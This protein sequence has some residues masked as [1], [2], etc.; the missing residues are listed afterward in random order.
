MRNLTKLCFASFAIF[1]LS[2]SMFAQSFLGSINGTVTDSTGAVV[3]ESNVTLTEVTTGIQQTE[4]SNAAGNYSFPDLKPGTYMVAVSKVGFK[5]A[6][7][8]NIILTAN[9]TSRFDAVLEVGSATQTIEVRALAPTMNTENAEISGVLS[10]NELNTLPVINRSTLY[11][12]MTNSNVY[13]GNGSSHSLG[14]T[15]G[16]STNFTIDGVSSNAAVFGNQVGP[17]TEESFDAVGELKTL[18]SNNSAEYPAIGT[19]MIA[20]RSGTNQFHG[21]LFDIESN[22]ALNARGFIPTERPKGPTLHDFGADIGGPVVIPGV[23]NGHNRTFFHFT[24]EGNYYPGE[25]SGTAEVPTPLMQQGDFSELLPASGVTPAGSICAADPGWC[26]QLTDPASGKPFSGNVIPPGRITQVS[27]NVQQFG[28]VTPNALSNFAD[29]YDWVGIFPS[30]SHD[31]RYV[32]RVDHQASSKDSISFRTSIRDL[33]APKQYYDDTQF[34]FNEVRTTQN[35]FLGWTHSF[36][37][38]LLNEFRFGFSR[39]A[40]NIADSHANGAAT[41]QALGFTGIDYSTRGGLSGFP[42]VNYETMSGWPDQEPSSFWR[43]Q[44]EEILDNLTYIKGKHSLKAG[45]LARRSPM[46]I[47]EYTSQGCCTDFG[48]VSFDGFATGFDYADFMLGLPHFA[49]LF[50]R[51]IPSAMQMNEWG[52]YAQ[53]NYQ[54]SPRLT[55]NLGLRWDYFPSITDKHDLNYNFDLNN[56]AVVLSSERSEKYVSPLYAAAGVVSPIPFEL[57]SAAGMPART[58]MHNQT[59]NISPRIGFAYRLFG[60]DRTVVRGGW[61]IYYNRLTYTRQND[62]SAGPFSSDPWYTNAVTN[63]AGNPMTPIMQFPDPFTGV[64]S[65]G[66]QSVAYISPYLRTP[67]T[68][69]WNLTF[70]HQFPHSVV[71]SLTYRGL[72]TTQLPYGGD[73]NKPLPSSNPDGENYFRYPNFYAVTQILS[74][75]TQNLN[76]MDLTVERRFSRGLTFHSAWT[77]AHNLTDTTSDTEGAGN[78]IQNFYDRKAEYG[79][80]NFMPRHRWA[81]YATYDLPFGNGKAFASGVSSGLN[82]LVGGWQMSAVTLVQTGLFFTP[83]FDTLDPS[84]TRTYGG[85]ADCVG[86]PYPANQ[87]S[88]NWFNKSAFAIPPSGRF[89]NCGNN[90]LEGPPLDNF[91]LG[92]FKNFMVKEKLRIQFRLTSANVLNLVNLGNPH[93]DTSVGS[94]GKITSQAG[95]KKDTLGGG[96]RQILLGLRLEF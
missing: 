87:T 28:F 33:P 89:G 23:Y 54:V 37:P 34:Y 92:L 39:Y 16:T 6:R 32:V 13:Q 29:G 90:V 31:N 65:I 45:I 72:K 67:M 8:S 62:F 5:E 38:N 91:D 76:A 56:G 20:T 59:H 30:S 10:N 74:G 43:S 11:F 46:N 71:T 1:A 4:R 63:A 60:D 50:T 9:Q 7:S 94:F 42:I 81:S 18:V 47:D 15:R 41:T 3:P 77:W 25:Y 48:T 19:L 79:N 35:A 80:V 51:A 44:T 88:L 78:G 96:A 75:A 93:T 66:T 26:V 73:S 14:G 40:A 95:S 21:D 52:F 82:Q 57:P 85:R 84:N 70:E 64:G 36:R 83:T 58:L 24:Y 22:N 12:I 69:Q 17:M 53:D 2:A 68:Q 27:K 55:L 61:G 49:D 86:N